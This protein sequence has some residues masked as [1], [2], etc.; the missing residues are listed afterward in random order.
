MIMRIMRKGKL[1]S[2]ADKKVSKDPSG[3]VCAND[4]AR[5]DR[6]I[7]VFGC[8]RCARI[9]RSP[10][11][12]GPRRSHYQHYVSRAFGGFGMVIVESTAVA[13]EGRITP[14]DLGLWG[15]RAD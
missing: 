5:G 3:A 8:R 6:A 7:I 11:M 1:L 12:V 2:K 13:P 4:A 15:R 14:C 9:R 10:A